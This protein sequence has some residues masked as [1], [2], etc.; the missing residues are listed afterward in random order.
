MKYLQLACAATLSTVVSLSTA[1]FTLDETNRVAISILSYAAGSMEDDIS[2]TADYG[3]LRLISAQWEQ[4]EEI[5]R[6]QNVLVSTSEVISASVPDRPGG[7]SSLLSVLAKENIDISYMYSVF[8]KAN[9]GANMVFKV[10]DVD[11]VEKILVE[12]GFEINTID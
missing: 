11:G 3:V 5:L 2:E 4:A 9:S 1:A 6:A 12:N 7:L 8:G 10:N